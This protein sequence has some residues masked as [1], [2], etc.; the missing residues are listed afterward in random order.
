VVYRTDADAEAVVADAAALGFPRAAPGTVDVAVPGDGTAAIRSVPAARVGLREALPVLLAGPSHAQPAWRRGPDG[1]LAWSLAARLGVRLVATHH[2]APTL[3]PAG[4]EPASPSTGESAEPVVHGGWRVLLD[5]H[6]Q[7]RALADRISMALPPAAHALRRGEGTVWSAQGL[8]HAFLDAVADSLAREDVEGER[9]SGR[10]RARLLPWTARWLEAAVDPVDPTVPLRD[11]AGELL[12]GIRAWEGGDDHTDLGLTEVRLLSPTEQDGTWRLEFGVRTPT[13]ALLDAAA[14]WDPPE[15][16]AAAGGEDPDPILLQEVLLRGMGRCARVFSA[17]DAALREPA[18]LGLDLDLDLA[19]RFIR[20][21]APLLVGSDVIVVLPDDLAEEPPRIRLRIDDAEVLDE[22]ELA[23]VIGTGDES[24]L[25]ASYQ[26][27]V[28]LGDEALDD[29]AL[30][31]LLGRGAPLVR[32]HD[33]WVRVDPDVRARLGSLTGGALPLAE[34]LLLGLGGSTTADALPGL[35]DRED[36]G[37]VE[38]ITGGRVAALL[39]RL[40]TAA[41][42]P[43]VDSPPEGFVGELRPYQERGVA[44]LQGMAELNLGAILADSMGLGKTIQLIAHLLARGAKGPHLV[45]CPTSVVGNW[46]REIGRFAPE[47][48]VTRF[49]GSERPEN[50]DGVTGVVVTS[51]GVVRRDTDVLADVSWDVVTLDEAQHVK[52]PS[53]AGAK[54][55]RRLEAQQ[56]VVLTGTPLENRLGELWSLLDVTNRGLLGTRS[57]FGRRYVAPIERRRDPAAAARLRRVVAPFILRREK[58]DPA[59]VA[60]LPPKI[61]RTVACSLTPEQAALYQAAVDRVLGS[62]ALSGASSMERRGRV[63][64]LLT[65]LKQICNHPAQALKERDPTQARVDVLTGRSGKLA[66]A[67][68]IIHAATGAGDQV[69]VFT[70]YVAMGR[71]L[72]GQL[73]H[74]LGVE[75]P[76][77]HGSVAAGARDAMVAAFQGETA[78]DVPPV[79]IVSLRAGGTGLNL[80]AATHVLHYD[81]WWNPAVEDQATDRAHR[82]GQ[83]RTVEVHKL[84]TAG[85]V[86]ERVADLLEHKRA[87]ADT[88]VG[89]GEQWITELGE[90]EL[91]ELVALSATA[92]ELDEDPFEDETWGSPPSGGIL[93]EREVRS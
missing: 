39:E 8:L 52:N 26:W 38:V 77:L 47:L 37:P 25:R 66:A 63:L 3:V 54:A 20:D 31:A 17:L 76:F 92:E 22:V 46:E 58:T 34:A 15:E 78:G 10:P 65:E 21:A 74:D 61:E 11:G 57:R 91:R 90:D 42:A 49:H 88:V 28:A 85:T 45:V 93:D 69:L 48:A 68:E 44:W 4:P 6:P 50:L 73:Q 43:P 7:S 83:D 72:V 36:L 71:L 53:T 82:I 41:D 86:E 35:E 79:L 80:T 32:W 40:R 30:E 62:D 51:Y 12:A 16:L 18:P 5:E 70:Q 2:I 29:E 27:E 19:W 75:V 60:D 55:V 1:L 89:A 13:G 87:L 64:A 59:V 9:R 67:R 33:R 14:V 23:D 24:G 56:V 84:V 81:R